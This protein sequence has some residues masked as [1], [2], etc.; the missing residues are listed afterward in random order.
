MLPPLWDIL[1]ALVWMASSWLNLRILLN[2]I[3]Q[4]RSAL[5]G[6][7]RPVASPILVLEWIVFQAQYGDQSP[8]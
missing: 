6:R 3:P 4:L 1:L 2:T 7:L 5:S 8:K